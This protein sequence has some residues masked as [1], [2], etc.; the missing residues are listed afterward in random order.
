MAR[1]PNPGRDQGN[2]GEIL[3]DYLLQSHTDTG[4]LKPGSVVGETI[5]IGA[6]DA[7]KLVPELQQQLTSMTTQSAISLTTIFDATDTDNALTGKAVSDYF[8]STSTTQ[9]HNDV[10]F[11]LTPTNSYLSTTGTVIASVNWRTSAPITVTPGDSYIYFGRTNIGGAAIA[12]AGYTS[13]GA[14]TATLLNNTIAST[15]NGTSF[16]VPSN[17][18][19][20]R[21]CSY[22]EAALGLKSIATTQTAVIKSSLL[23]AQTAS[24]PRAIGKSWGAIG[25]SIWAVDGTI[26]GIQTLVKKIYS[27]TSYANY[28]YSGN[29]LSA[30]VIDTPT[31]I[32]QP[33][34]TATWTS[35]DIYTFDSITNDFKLNRPIGT[36]DDFLNNT[37][38]ATFY[39][40]L[41]VLHNTLKTLN[42]KY[43]MIC[44]NALKRDNNGYTSWSTNTV[45]HTLT[46]YSIAI[47]WVANYLSWRFVNQFRDSGINNDNLL[48][49][50]NDGLHPNTAGYLRL[51]DLWAAQ[52]GIIYNQSLY[53]A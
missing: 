13:S 53:S 18:V 22:Y 19:S 4:A 10:I 49:Y 6:I 46:D 42:P 29:S 11:S 17:V 8:L 24:V 15:P 36:T 35:K 40:A 25:T 45:G 5:A 41:R 48:L 47:E 2:W 23:P 21:I 27:F 32:L 44:S 7:S 1:L 51:S 28:S 34:K 12:V 43:I 50:T 39:G 16:T 52:F 14:F 20:V 9:V 33:S 38:V 26:T 37:G 3:N 30:A 31:C